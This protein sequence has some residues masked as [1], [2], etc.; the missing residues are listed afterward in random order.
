L[1]EISNADAAIALDSI[2]VRFLLKDAYRRVDL[3]LRESA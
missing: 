2:G 3:T 1:H